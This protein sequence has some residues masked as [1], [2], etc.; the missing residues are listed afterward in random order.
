MTLYQFISLTEEEKIKTV[1]RD[2]V[3]LDNH[4]S[5]TEMLSCYVIDVF[6]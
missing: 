4:I 6:L 1:W 3:F 5:K 2:G